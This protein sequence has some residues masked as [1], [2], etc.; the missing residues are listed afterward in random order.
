MAV[1]VDLLKRK[2][3]N[4]V[5][6]RP[7]ASDFTPALFIGSI[8]FLPP[9][10]GKF[11]LENFKEITLTQPDSQFPELW[12]IPAASCGLE[13]GKVYFYWFKVRNTE[14][15]DAANSKQVIYCTDPL[16]YTIDRRFRAP[17]PQN[18]PTG[19]TGISSFD[20]AGITLYRGGKLIPCDPGNPE[21]PNGV[22]V[23][24]GSDPSPATLPSN[25]KL[26][27]YELPTRWTRITSR[28][29]IEIGNGTF[30]D[31][32]A[33]LVPELSAPTFPTVA[34][35]NNR[36]HLVELG[37]NAL[38]LLPPADSEQSE[39]WGYGTS[40]YF[41]ADFEL[42]FPASKPGPTASFDLANMIKTCHGKGIR[43]FK[44]TV[45]AFATGTS[46]RNVNF[47][48]FFVHWDS[49]DPEQAGRNGFGGD[50]IKYA[51]AVSGY[52]PV[53]GSKTTLF[54]SRAFLK[55]YLFHWM[56]YYHV[57]GL[58]LDSVNNIKNFDFL[59]EV[60]DLSRA[61][62]KDRGGRDD[63]FLVVGE[64]IPIQ[65]A[66]LEQK[67]LDSLWNEEFKN[68][69]KPA[70]VGRNAEGEQSFEQC[71]RKMIDCRILGFQDGSQ[72]INY[73]TSHDVEG[74]GAERL[75]T[76]LDFNGVFKKEQRAKLA[77]VCLLTAVGIPMILSGEEFVDE[78]DLD[79]FKIPEARNDDERRD[80]RD[81]RKQ[82]DPV[83]FSRLDDEWRRRVFFYVARLVKFRTQSEALAV[84]DTDFIHVDFE[85]GKRVLAWKRG[86]GDNIVVVV[87]NFSDWGTAEPGNPNSKYVVPNWPGLPSGKKWREITQERDVPV[88]WAGKEPLFPWEA[89]VYAAV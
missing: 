56:T 27:I 46:I 8:D 30:Q 71:V 38:E 52:D 18:V 31:V 83:N 16:A 68:I 88:Q 67:R 58:R 43:V 55:A 2:E 63:N 86:S 49:G 74:T 22:V 69:V 75:Y 48:D 81:F 78:M 19:L 37:I 70:V 65:Q 53:S 9:A 5:L 14:P 77:F 34:A 33:L 26:V 42:G 87:A 82:V 47:L 80:I 66:M 72:A 3:T 20:P 45:M 29:S 89:K 12:E 41:A 50:L 76:F 21:A 44:D 62:W 17:V 24:L 23:D 15:F 40:N 84:N 6:W 4:F 79:I 85:E 25:N 1:T 59:Q 60:K 64:S 35:L 36:A 13:E 11:K 57:D 51:F 54:P 10:S 28:D 39:K 73:I 7:G 61:I 32:L